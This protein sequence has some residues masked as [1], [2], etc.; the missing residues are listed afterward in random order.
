MLAA[1]K[2]GEGKKRIAYEHSSFVTFS[3]F[4]KD[5]YFNKLWVMLA[6]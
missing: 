1:I 6:R 3:H 5:I 2:K 4:H